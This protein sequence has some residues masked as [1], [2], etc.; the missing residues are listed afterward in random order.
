[1]LLPPCTHYP[2]PK[3]IILTEGNIPSNSE[4]L[5]QG[6]KVKISH[7]VVIFTYALAF[8]LALVVKN[9]PANV[10]E[11]KDGGLISGWGRSPGGGHGN[12]LQNS[13]LGNPMDREAWQHRTETT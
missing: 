6:R 11:V 7:L 2:Y 8:Q 9:P 10:G 13:C 1:M 4:L 5:G 12:S 3:H